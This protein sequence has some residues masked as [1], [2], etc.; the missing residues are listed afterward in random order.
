MTMTTTV[1]PPAPRFR[2]FDFMA[3][4]EYWLEGSRLGYATCFTDHDAN[5]EPFH[6]FHPV[7]ADLGEIEDVDHKCVHLVLTVDRVS[8]AWL[9]RRAGTLVFGRDTRI[10]T[11]IYPPMTED[12]MVIPAPTDA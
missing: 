6:A 2:S 9:E 5:G 3:G 10:G 1:L 8:P 11:R 4:D 12:G 7:V